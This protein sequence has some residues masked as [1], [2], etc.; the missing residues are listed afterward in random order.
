MTMI[1]PT[2]KAYLNALKDVYVKGLVVDPRGKPTSELLN[3]SFTVENP[4][5]RPIV[6][7]D[8][9]RN[10]I[11]ADYTEKE[12]V[13]YKSQTNSVEDFAKASSFWREV[14]NPDGTINSAYGYLIWGL[15]SC[16]NVDLERE[17]TA[18][19]RPEMRTPWEWAK[20]SL[21]ADKNTRQAVL[22]FGLP[23]H[24]WFGNKDVT[25]TMH[26]QFLIRDDRLHFSIVMRSNDLVKGLVYDMPFFIYL[27]ERMVEELKPVWPNLQVGCYHH[28]AHSLHFYHSDLSKVEAM[29]GWNDLD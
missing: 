25:C 10:R 9:A 3:Y 8:D 11:I 27:I 20:L 14:A 19:S 23:S 13:L 26:G 4:D 1:T 15:K 18:L 22:R 7:L 29:I 21:T 12:L 16:G 17:G 28:F 5:S 2:S 6:T 24:L